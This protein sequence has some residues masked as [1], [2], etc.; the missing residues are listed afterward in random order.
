MFTF[1]LDPEM[2]SEATSPY[3]ILY[4]GTG[5]VDVVLYYGSND[6]QETIVSLT[7]APITLTPISMLEKWTPAKY[8]KLGD[9]IEP[10][11]SN[12]LMYK[13]AEPGTSGDGEPDWGT[14]RVGSAVNSGTAQFINYGAKFVPSD[15]RLA[16]SRSGL[17]EAESGAGISLGQSMRGGAPIAVYL[18]ITNRFIDVRSDST[19]PCI[20]IGTNKVRLSKKA[21]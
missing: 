1:W 16:L 21:A 15:V 7:D 13:C 12:G 4:N 5:S 8:Y 19:D 11:V 18:R 6:P 14:G 20:F 17:D 9:I 10:T 3:P 2:T